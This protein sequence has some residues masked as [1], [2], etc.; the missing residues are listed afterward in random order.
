MVW[1]GRKMGCPPIALA[2]AAT[3]ILS[4]MTAGAPSRWI[5]LN[6]ALIR[7]CRISRGLGV[8]KMT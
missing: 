7:H 8:V 3:V 5:S 1:K 4:E 2:L 6:T